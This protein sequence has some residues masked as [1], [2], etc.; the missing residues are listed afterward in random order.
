MKPLKLN[1]SAFITLC[2]CPADENIGWKTKLCNKLFTTAAY[3]T[4]I[5]F[6][7]TS[8]VFIINNYKQNLEITLYAL[9]QVVHVIAPLYLLIMAHVQRK[10]LSNIFSTLQTI[11]D[12]CKLSRNLGIQHILWKINRFD[13]NLFWVR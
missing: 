5:G 2:V 4:L 3:I 11:Y 6:L 13:F 12:T 7:I 8:I 1:Q 10:Q 9:L